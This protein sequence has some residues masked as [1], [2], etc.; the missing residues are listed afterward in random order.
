MAVMERDT[1]SIEY[2]GPA[3]Q[4]ILA[5][6]E[7]EVDPVAELFHEYEDDG[8]GISDYW[9]KNTSHLE[10]TELANILRALRKV[11]GHIGQNVGRIEWAGMSGDTRGAIVLDPGL[12]SGNY[13][14]PGK[15]MDYLVGLVTHEAYHKTEWSDLVWKKLEGSFQAM[16]VWEM[17]IFQKIVYTGEDIYVDLIS[18]KSILGLYTGLA[19]HIAM[20]LA[21]REL[22]KGKGP[23]T[24]DELLILWWKRAFRENGIPLS[25]KLY[26]KPL[27]LLNTLTG[28]LKD[29]AQ[30][31]KAVINRCESRTEL[32]LRTWEKIRALIASWEVVD[33]T[34]L[35]Y[36]AGY[37]G[38]NKQ[39]SRSG[40]KPIQ[41]RLSRQKADSIEERLAINSSDITPIIR[42]VVGDNE[43]IVPTSRWDFNIPAHPVID[44]KLVSRL[45]AIFQDYAER[46]TV[47]NRGLT[48]GRIDQR[49]LYRAPTTGRCF[50]DK[51]KLPVLDWNICLLIDASGSM[52]GPKWRMVENTMGV[53]HKAFRG[54]QNRLR[55][56]AYFEVE[57][58]CMISRLITRKNILS[59][60][61][62]G[63]TASGQAIIAAAYFMPR[64]SRRRFL[65]H[66]TDGESNFGCDVRYGIDYCKAQ[67]IHLVT[68]GVAYKDR[69]AMQ[70]QYG[71]SIQFLDHFGQL[72]HALEK[73]LKWTLL[74]EAKK[75]PG[76]G[77]KGQQGAVS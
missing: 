18:E 68:L 5:D 7:P 55:A 56:Y 17:V 70:E 60:P 59:V 19:R 47:F 48:S 50:M 61:P 39:R 30:S 54:F 1:K 65:I 24:V 45:K 51:Q 28:Q 71:N 25:A 73:L 40:K 4:R 31:G 6:P 66:I 44:H 41:N 15:K 12:V 49:R 3:M 74:Y 63:Q 67:G 34:L 21:S 16:S 57:G 10:A 26:E 9:R 20:E 38:V 35:W 52:S 23:V 29:V 62:S 8:K 14:V 72:P 75:L 58:V 43:D 46:K 37:G 13:P 11:A 2:F 33:R 76:L 27:A 32:Y 64:D 42:S 22:N 77:A 36:P 69:T 53:I